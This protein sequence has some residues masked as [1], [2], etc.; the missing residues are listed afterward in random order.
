MKEPEE[1]AESANTPGDGRLEPWAKQ[2]AKVLIYAAVLCLP[3][4][5]GRFFTGEF[6]AVL[7]L[8]PLVGLIGTLVGAGELLGRYRD[9][10]FL[11]LAQK[12]SILY[13][14][15]NAVAAMAAL[16]LI[17]VFEWDFG[18]EQ[19]SS[20]DTVR[21]IQV[22]VAGFGAMALLRSSLFTARI[23]GN[24]VQVGPA[25]VL[26]TVLNAADAEV[27]RE[28]AERRA[29]AARKIMSE[30]DADKAKAILPLFC[31][32]LTQSSLSENDWEAMTNKIEDIYD[33]A[34]DNRS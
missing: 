1:T 18:L 8:Y 7:W 25:T 27:D 29:R 5:L 23:G 9:E 14:A 24:D 4:I 11:A 21:V 34:S 30:V 22:L 20:Q 33:P 6:D 2:T 13:L 19:A 16:Y 31:Y 17:G 12:A 32:R 3:P 26:Q 28:A 15:V 10:P